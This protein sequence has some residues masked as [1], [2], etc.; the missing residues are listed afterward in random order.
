MSCK[1][2]VGMVLMEQGDSGILSAVRLLLKDNPLR[3]VGE[4]VHET[5]FK[6]VSKGATLQNVRK[7]VGRPDVLRMCRG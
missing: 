1:A 5:R 2:H 6:L 3:V 4:V 7:V